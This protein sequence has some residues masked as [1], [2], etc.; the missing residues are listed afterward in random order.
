VR[1]L[2]ATNRDLT[3]EVAGGAFRQHLY[4]ASLVRSQ[5]GHVHQGVPALQSRGG[6]CTQRIASSMRQ[7]SLRFVARWS[8]ELCSDYR[9]SDGGL[10][11][12]VT[13]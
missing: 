10:R 2:A 9:D 4:W 12:H 1:V 5:A 7:P 6:S 3:D 13:R 11:S 8:C